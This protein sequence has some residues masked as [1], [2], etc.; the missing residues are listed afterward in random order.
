MNAQELIDT[1]RM[2]VAGDKGLL[3][4]AFPAPGQAPEG[5]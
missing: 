3:T 5:E 1:A 2:Q 4:M